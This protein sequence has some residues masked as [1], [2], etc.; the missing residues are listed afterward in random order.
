MNCT[1][2]K[3]M[4]SWATCWCLDLKATCTESAHHNARPSHGWKVYGPYFTNSHYL[5][6]RILWFATSTF[7]VRHTTAASIPQLYSILFN[8]MSRHGSQPTAWIGMTHQLSLKLWVLVDRVVS[9]CRILNPRKRFGKR[10]RPGQTRYSSTMRPCMRFWGVTRIPFKSAGLKKIRP[11]RLK[12]LLNIWPNMPAIHRPDFDAFRRKLGSDRSRGTKHRDSFIWPYI[13][14]E[15]LSPLRHCPCCW[16]PE[17][18]IL[19]PI[20]LSPTSRPW[21]WDCQVRQLYLFS[22]MSISWF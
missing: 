22:W 21:N 11:Q 14:Q 7:L 6:H 5:R 10:P 19:L 18:A 4:A 12:I 1:L 17:V 8:D 9:P 16:T 3:D 20:A 15:D 13:N 2:N